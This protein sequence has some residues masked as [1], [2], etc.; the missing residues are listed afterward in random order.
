MWGSDRAARA[1]CHPFSPLQE[2]APS[3]THVTVLI[4]NYKVADLVLDNLPN[5]TAEKQGVDALDIVIV[6][7]GS[8]GDDAQILREGIAAQGAGERCTLIVSETNGGF[9]SGNNIGFR[10]IAEREAQPDHV[11]LV[12]PDTRFYERTLRA[13]VDTADAHPKAGGLGGRAL[14]EDGTPRGCAYTFPTFAREA[15]RLPLLYNLFPEHVRNVNVQVD[16]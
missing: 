12:N 13:L 3:M 5:L 9:A 10:A 14:A 11:V 15:S 6:E 2:R 8:P 16:D 1:T 4:V 7:N